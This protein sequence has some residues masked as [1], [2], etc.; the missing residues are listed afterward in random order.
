MAMTDMQL[1]SLLQV[2]KEF[3]YQ[4]RRFEC[5]EEGFVMPWIDW[6]KSESLLTPYTVNEHKRPYTL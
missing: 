3:A 6:I 4:H 5:I 1:K 2:L